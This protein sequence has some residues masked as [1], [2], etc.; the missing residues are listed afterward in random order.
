MKAAGITG[1]YTDSRRVTGDKGS[2]RWPAAGGVLGRRFFRGFWCR[3]GLGERAGVYVRS[4]CTAAGRKSTPG[5]WLGRGSTADSSISR[6]V[7]G[8][9]GEGATQDGGCTWFVG[10]L[11]DRC[12]GKRSHPRGAGCT[13]SA[14]AREDGASRQGSRQPTAG[15]APCQEPG[16]R[17]RWAARRVVISQAAFEPET[18]PG[19]PPLIFLTSCLRA[20]PRTCAPPRPAAWGGRGRTCAGW[21]LHRRDQGAG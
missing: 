11:V 12:G 19:Q 2:G 18:G 3:A 4:G 7:S 15:K 10:V 8:R 1:R 9:T 16:C 21:C 17:T 13:W 14:G 6:E 20:V 5:P